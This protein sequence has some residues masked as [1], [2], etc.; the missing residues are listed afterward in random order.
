[1]MRQ[2]FTA[3][4]LMLVKAF[5]LSIFYLLRLFFAFILHMLE[6]KATVLPSNASSRPS[7]F[8]SSDFEPTSTVS[9]STH[10][11]LSLEFDPEPFFA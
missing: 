5:V 10:S 2:L 3:D 7:L 1:M 4:G 8:L 6:P 11:S 9:I